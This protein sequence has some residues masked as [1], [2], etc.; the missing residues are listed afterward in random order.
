[1][2]I[3]I[4]TNGDTLDFSVDTR[5]G[6]AR[7]LILFD[8]DT[9]EYQVLDNT[10]NVEAVK[11]SGIRTAENVSKLGVECVI[12]RHCGSL[13]F[14]ML[15]A[16]GIEVVLCPEGTTVAE[17]IE[18]FRKGKLHPAKEADIDSYWD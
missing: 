10:R 16:A 12:T 14:S 8:T 4:P 9:S 11:G 13:A 17:A 1:M 18:M 15:Q 2:N 5:L 6:H 7:K 3:V